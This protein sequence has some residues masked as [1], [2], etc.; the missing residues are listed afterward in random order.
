VKYRADIDGLRAIAVVPVVLFHA[1]VS[2]FS[3]GFVGVDIFFVISGYLITSIISLEIDDKRFSIFSFYRR[4]IRR[5]FPALIVVVSF[6]IIAGY[7]LLTPNDYESLGQSVIATALFISNLFFWQHTNYFEAPVSENPLLHTW[8]LAIEE[9]FYL[10]YPFILI[11]I[12]T[13]IRTARTVVIASFGLVSFI[14]CALMVNYK[15]SATFYL[16]PTRVWELF[17]GGLIA[18][19]AMPRITSLIFASVIAISGLSL[20]IFSVLFYSQ[21][22]RFPGLTALAPVLGATFLIWSGMNRRTFIHYLLATRPLKEVGKASYSL[23]LWHFPLI[24]FASYSVIGAPSL[25]VRISLCIAAVVISFISL[26]FVEQP[27]RSSVRLESVDKLVLSALLSMALICGIGVVIAVS[28]GVRGRMDS[29]SIRILDAEEDKY[30]HHIECMSLGSKIVPP[31]EACELGYL[32]AV[33]HLLLWGDSHAMVTATALEQSAKSH[34]AAFLFA[35]SVDCP[36]GLNFSIDPDTGPPFVSTAAYRY[37]GEYNKQM[38]KLALGNP[39]IQAVVLSSRWTNWRIGEPGAKSENPVDI[40]LRSAEGVAKSPL[41]NRSIF[42]S[43]F[44]ALVKI[45]TESGKTVWIVGPLPEPLSRI[46]K[47]L[48]VEHFGLDDT[49]LNVSA[50][51]FRRRHKVIMAEFARLAATYPVKF[52]WPHRVLCDKLQCRVVDDGKPLFLDDNH[53]TVYA[54]RK[55]SSLYDEVFDDFK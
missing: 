41:E 20:I 29:A 16:G 42:F 51:E 1:G 22:T 31:D 52:I 10:F 4:R 30:R 21:S 15:P 23:Y 32:G 54:A 19:G 40:R 48:Y 17:I 53:L 18:L 27:F 7:I 25:V 44:E 47:A 3:G 11:L 46:P 14:V 28:G 43:G 8:S 36:I 38:I 2:G 33:P 35:A 9:Q 13:Y 37:C 45:L 12:S 24:A 50:R 26:R 49:N 55:T 39:G 34:K 5:I 6:C